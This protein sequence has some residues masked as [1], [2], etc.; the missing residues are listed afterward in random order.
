MTHSQKTSPRGEYIL[1]E[2][3]RVQESPSLAE[4]FKKLKSLTVELGYYDT[5]GVSKNSQVKYTVNL[6]HAKSVFRFSCH[7]QECV[8]GDFDLSEEIAKAVAAHRTT[9]SSEICCQG[10]RNRATIDTVRC[11]NILRYKLTLGY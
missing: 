3:Q 4:K 2:N 1:Q 5:K 7:N 8:R 6:N 11:N 9:V 10:W